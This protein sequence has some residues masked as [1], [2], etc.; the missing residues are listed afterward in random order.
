MRP[1]HSLLVWCVVTF[2][3]ACLGAE[4]AGAG[5]DFRVV[6]EGA[7]IPPLVERT[8]AILK[9][10]LETRVS[11]RVVRADTGADL[12]L[13]VDPTLAPEAYRIENVGKA[14]K[15]SGGTPRGLLYGVG[16]FLHTSEYGAD[17]KASAWRG[18]EQP[19]GTLRGM[20]FASHFHNW[21]HVASE[22][23]R[24]RYLEDLSLWGM[25]T[26]MAVLP[27]ITLHG[28][29][30]PAMEPSL[31]MLRGYAR[32]AHEL[33]LMFCTGL[34][35]AMF[36]DVPA[37]ARAKPLADPLGR[38]GNSGYPVCPSI[39]AGRAY[40][41]DVTRQLCIRLQ[42]VGLDAICF[43]PYD[44]GG[45]PCEQCRPWGS[46]GYL[47][48]AREMTAISREYFPRLKTVVS[49]WAF[50]TPPEGEWEGLTAALAQGREPWLDFILAD[51]H[52]DY[53]RYPLEVGVPGS[54]PL[55]N[56]PEISMWGNS[57]WGGFGANPLPGRLQRLWNQVKHVV[58]GGFPYSEG[59]YEDMNK[60][61]ELQF[62][63]DPERTARDTLREYSEYEFGAGTAPA[64]LPL[65]D[66]LE[67]AAANS[68]HHEPVDS[69]AVRQAAQDGAAL[70]GRLAAWAKQNWRWEIL[71][72]RSQLDRERFGG[73]S[74]DSPAAQAAM[75]RLVEI[76]H[77]QVVTDDP[78]HARVRPPVRQAVDRAGIK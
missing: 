8:F 41:M 49:T 45:C 44:E 54:R 50:D 38:R 23:E 72:L 10:R 24:R 57:P 42:G 55:L 35:N 13:A 51:A 31:Q 66:A 7:N 65:V 37:A 12:I 20:Y 47:K 28:W 40:L 11:L 63:W 75:L 69:Q 59:I 64:V 78:Y 32:A 4:P 76:Y 74:L 43:W 46:N 22:E 36:M 17:F 27:A 58:R 19:R 70:Q 34:G 21:N 33:D 77:S 73:G 53:P 56:F 29:D 39:P 6:I 26:I 9:D 52:E 3:L 25:N 71:Y 61:V 2:G 18:Q 1:F 14:V 30:D 68:Y 60:V 48:M 62:Y 16:K 15:V 67:A 5:R